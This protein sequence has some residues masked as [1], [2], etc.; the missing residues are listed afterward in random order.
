M[1]NKDIL[2]KP[3][4]C[5]AYLRKVHDGKHIEY[6]DATYERGFGI[7]GKRL[8]KGW[9][10]SSYDEQ[11][12]GVYERVEDFGGG[13]FLKTYYERAKMEYHGVAVEIKEVVITAELYVDV[14]EDDY[15]YQEYVC[16]EPKD[17][18]L[19]AKVY[20]ANGKSHLVPI[21]DLE[22]EE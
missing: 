16:K 20:Y 9:Y 5:H 15:H 3:V 6:N 12:N 17:T 22:V 10:Y 21:E 2:L 8:E 11:G 7:G 19:C 14:N 13:D 4:K 1:T 18:L